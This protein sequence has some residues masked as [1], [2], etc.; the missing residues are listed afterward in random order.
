M[1]RRIFCKLLLVAVVVFGLLAFSGVLLAQGRS[2]DAFERVMEVQEEHTERL[3]SINGVEGTAIG[4]D[5]NDQPAVKVFTAGPG[6]AG[7]PRSIDGVPVQ[8]VVTGKFYALVKPDKPP[9]KPDKPPKPEPDEEID[10]TARFD[11]PVP[12]GVSTGNVESNSAGTIGCRVTDGTDVYAL[13]NNH[14]YALENTASDNSEVLQPGVY[15]GGVPDDVIGTLANY[16]DI[17]FPPN[18]DAPYNVWPQN[19]VD[20]AIALC[21]T[22]TLGNS[23]PEGEGGGYGVP[24]SG[25]VDAFVG[26]PV[27]KYGRT[28]G[29]TKGA[30]SEINAAVLVGYSDNKVALFV[31]QIVILPNRGRG[32]SAGGD[33]GSLI[34][35]NDNGKNPVGLLFAGGGRR[36]IA[37]PID[38]VIN[39]FDVTVD[40][41]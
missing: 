36:T 20:A 15:D 18:P 2:A 11:H 38:L 41:N 13:S 27:Q 17:D 4:L 14:V 6:V 24:S 25:T 32:F 3:L 26:Q 22:D 1:L 8:V 37:N 19:T 21:T 33:S 40:G 28:T 35:T 31:G 16:V 23:T 9:G 5:R 10:P 29:L 7:I 39:S 30:V 12:I 34:V